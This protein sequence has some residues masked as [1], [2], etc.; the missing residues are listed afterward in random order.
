MT[1]DLSSL[2]EAIANIEGPIL[3]FN[4]GYP[5]ING[6]AFGPLLGSLL[7][8][9]NVRRYGVAVMGT[10]DDYIGAVTLPCAIEKAKRKHSHR[11]VI[12]TDS[13]QTNVI[14]R[15]SLE[16]GMLVPGVGIEKN[17]PPIGDYCL[18]AGTF[19]RHEGE[20]QLATLIRM[21]DMD[22]N[23]VEGYA[24]RACDAI[25]AGLKLRNKR[26]LMM[27]VAD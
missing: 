5:A 1:N 15:F 21:R 23:V 2:T 12:A 17:L 25:V 16:Q 20:S 9:V 6:D 13:A 3:F 4:V 24:Q 19:T 7:R 8:K 26:K 27:E 22:R 14:G 18:M 11:T 10:E